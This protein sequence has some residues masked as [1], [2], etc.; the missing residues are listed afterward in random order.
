ML[1]HLLVG[2]RCLDDLLLAGVGCNGDA[3]ADL[4]VDLDW[5]FDFIVGEPFFLKG[6]EWFVGDGVVVAELLPEFLRDVWCDRETMTISGRTA[7]A[8]MVSGYVLVR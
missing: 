1:L 4:A 6:G 3:T 7:P 5:Q 8:G 2:K